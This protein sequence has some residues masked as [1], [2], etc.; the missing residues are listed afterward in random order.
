ML[1]SVFAIFDT[2]VKAWMRPLYAR[3]AQEM[4]RQFSEAVED[5]QSQLSRHPADFTLF[6]LGTFDDNEGTF[7]IFPAPVRL[8]MAQDF[9][10]KPALP[11]LVSDN[12]SK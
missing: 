8:A 3:N 4:L 7:E 1:L 6:Q 5:P 11:S 12:I 10:K 2:T 9:V